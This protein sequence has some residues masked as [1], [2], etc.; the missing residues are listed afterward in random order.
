MADFLK[1][2]QFIAVIIIESILYFN[3][4]Y[5]K[6]VKPSYGYWIMDWVC[7]TNIDRVYR[8]LNVGHSIG[9][10]KLQIYIALSS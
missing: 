4:R 8:T 6:V 9:H 7:C 10:F 3:D 2:R 5:R 1:I